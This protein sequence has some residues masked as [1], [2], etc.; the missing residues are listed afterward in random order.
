MANPHKDETGA[1]RFDGKLRQASEKRAEETTRIEQTAI[2]PGQ[3]ATRAGA[4][5]LQKNA[6]TL[7]DAWRSRVDTTTASMGN[8]ADQLGRAFGLSGEGAQQ[9]VNDR[10]AIPKLYSSGA[11]ISKCMTE[12]SR[13]YFEF[14]RR[15]I[16]SNMQRMNEL[17][18]CRTPHDVAA[19]QTDIVRQ[20]FEGVLENGR[21]MA[22][23]SM[24]LADEAAKHI[25]ENMGRAA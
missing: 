1:Q 6:E 20:Y 24:K 8:S 19:L 12:A 5:V 3:N 23:L 18:N 7:Q 14:V 13:E 10:S 15:Q 17:W 4:E 25:R 11:A 9:A 21:R 22:D 2:A 16:E